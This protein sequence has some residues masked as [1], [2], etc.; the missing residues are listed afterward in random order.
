MYIGK[1]ICLYFLLNLSVRMD[2]DDMHTIFQNTKK[3][4][5]TKKRF[6]VGKFLRKY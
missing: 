1:Q 2:H 6:V 5:K 4:K 3:K